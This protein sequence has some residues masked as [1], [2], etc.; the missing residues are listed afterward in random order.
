MG[1]K[2]K[3]QTSVE[4]KLH[5]KYDILETATHSSILAWRISWTE[6]PGRLQSM[7]LQKSRTRLSTH[8]R[9]HAHTHT[10]TR[11]LQVNFL[12]LNSKYGSNRGSLC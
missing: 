11:S 6:E 12:P 8:T 7:R 5:L 4:A 1:Y 10:H 9:T 3:N 2:E